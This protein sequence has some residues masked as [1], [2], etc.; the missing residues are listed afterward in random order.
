M[1]VIINGQEMSIDG[2]VTV[3]GLLGELQLEGRI[4]VEINKEIVPRSEFDR[5]PVREG[6]VIEIV[7]AIGGG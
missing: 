6:D 2:I 7:R 5:F 3:G 1:H 4:A